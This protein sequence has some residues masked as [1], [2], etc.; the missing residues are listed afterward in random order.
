[1]NQNFVSERLYSLDALRG[2]DML[3]I[4]G[5]E[6]VSTIG[7]VV[8]GKTAGAAV[9]ADVVATTAGMAAV[10]DITADNTC[11]F[12][13]LKTIPICSAFLRRR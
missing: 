2:L 12:Y 7:T 13:W 3:M 10:T 11:A 9:M 1:M 5:L 4:M 6:G 8:G